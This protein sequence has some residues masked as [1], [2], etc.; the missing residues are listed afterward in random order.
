VTGFARLMLVMAAL[1]LGGFATSARAA[2]QSFPLDEIEGKAD[3]PNTIIEYSS[4]TCPHCAHFH[5]EIWPELK[6]KWVD[7]GKA[8]FIMR[9]FPLDGRAMAA[10]MVA[11]CSGDHYF[12]FIDTFFRT[13]QGWGRAED[14]VAAIKTLGKFGGMSEEQIDSCLANEGL[15]D[16]IKQRQ[17]A[18]ASKYNIESTPTFVVNGHVIVGAEPYE[19][20]AKYLK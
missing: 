13:Q 9:D 18:G 5:A 7:T 16:Q 1:L 6:T 4:L 14:G 12:A 20:F 2:D 10:A 8:K 17:D 15:M 19:T 11:H 3:A